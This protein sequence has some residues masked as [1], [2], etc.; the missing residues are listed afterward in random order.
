[1]ITQSDLKNLIYLRNEIE[2]IKR[3]IKR[4]KPAEVVI[5]SVQG[6]SPV[7]P[8]VQHTVKIE[9]LETKKSQMNQYFEKLKRNKEKLEKE[10]KRIEAEIEK[11]PYSEI[12]QIIRLHYI[13]RLPYSQVMK[14]MGYNAPETPRI[15]LS[16]YLEEGKCDENEILGE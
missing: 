10:E 3:K 8:Y 14:I 6:S 16:R 5:D 13:D 4:Y 7:F 9:G 15:K 1:M 12:R 11:I 2:H